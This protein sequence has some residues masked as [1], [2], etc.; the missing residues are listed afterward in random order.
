MAG[1]SLRDAIT[2]TGITQAL[3]TPLMIW[4]SYDIMLSI[5]TGQIASDLTKPIDF[6]AFWLARDLGPNG[7]GK[8][9]TLKMLTGPTHET[10]VRAGGQ[11]AAGTASAANRSPA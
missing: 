3:S 8:S 1:Y 9:T 5:R 2:Y 6:H 10:T 7:A 4:G 11:P